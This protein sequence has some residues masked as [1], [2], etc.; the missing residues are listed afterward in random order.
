MTMAV[1]KQGF[2]YQSSAIIV[3]TRA[4]LTLVMMGGLQ[5]LVLM[6]GAL[7]APPPKVFLFFYQKSPPLTKPRDPPVNS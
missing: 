1:L 3:R 2:F 6:G 4:G 7:C 5:T